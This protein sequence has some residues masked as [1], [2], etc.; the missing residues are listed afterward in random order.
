MIFGIIATIALSVGVL[1]YFVGSFGQRRSHDVQVTKVLD[2]KTL[3]IRSKTE[4]RSVVLAGIGFPSGD[5]K[6]LNDATELVEDIANGRRF[7]MEILKE[8]DGLMYVDLRAANGDSLNELML[9]RGFAR[10]DFR[11]IG[12]VN[13]MLEAE[14]KARNEQLGIW[15]QNRQLFRKAS[16]S[17]EPGGSLAGNARMIDQLDEDVSLR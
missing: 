8:V 11:A 14:N 9:S 4:N 12:F 1:Y 13:S 15:N 2:G 7:R 16:N 3:E 17:S 10:F 6:A 5:E